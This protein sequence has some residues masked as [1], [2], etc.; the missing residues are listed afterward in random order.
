MSSNM[1]RSII[2]AVICLFIFSG[3]G[4]SFSQTT[5]TPTITLTTIPTVS[6]TP[7]INPTDTPLPTNTKSP[8]SSCNADR[9]IKNLKSKVSYQQYTILHNKLQ[10]KSFLA[11]WFVE[12]E[13]NPNSK[14][15]EISENAT[16]AIHKALILSQEL[17]KIDICVSE[18]FD[19]IN[20]VVVDQNYNGWFSG[21]IKTKDLPA[22][23]QTDKKQL[24]EISKMYEIGYERS[25]IPSKTNVKPS[26][27]CTWVEAKN[28]IHKHFASE[29]ENV[30]FY[31]VLDDV[32]VNVWAQ[33]DSKVDFLQLNLP[34]SLLN[35]ATEIEC[36]S[37]K[38]DRI[39][40]SIVDE[41]GDVQIIGLWN[42]SD[43][44]KQDI[45]KIQMLYQK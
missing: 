23:I 36:L 40:F 17:N 18:L 30:A 43:A 3:C 8:S 45:S 33:W 44:E 28:N 2:F 25:K 11:V 9:T 16:I 19:M 41:K 7:T 5:V 4:T 39:I 38:P 31:F 26:S 37:P 21:Q 20:A 10:G 14:E 35:I 12:P 13:I 34:A 15:S 24:D 32:G 22:E 6:A 1:S 29:R 42:I 27:G